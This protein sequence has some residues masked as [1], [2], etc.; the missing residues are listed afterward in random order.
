VGGLRGRFEAVAETGSRLADLE[1][2]S[3]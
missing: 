1:R 2:L 3:D